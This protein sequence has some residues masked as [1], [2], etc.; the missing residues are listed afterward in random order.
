MLK[1]PENIAFV[2]DTLAQN[3]Y[4][5]YIVGG[6]VRDASLGILPSDFDVTTSAKPKEVMGLFEKT[7]PTGIKHGTVTVISENQPV[8]VTTFRTDGEYNDSRH[9]LN[10]EFVANLEED[11]SRRDFTVNA[12]AYNEGKGLI[13]LFG[14]I[15]DLESKILRAVGD[16]EKRFKEDAL[17]ILRLFRFASQLDFSIEENTLKAALKLQKGLEKI[18]RERIFSEI[19]K[20][21]NGKNPKAILPL[22]SAGGLGFL[23]ITNTPDFTHIDNPDLKLF[24]FLN[25]SS[26]DPVGV[27]RELKASNRQIELT[28]KLLLLQDTEIKTRVQ[29]K[30]TLFSTD[31]DSVKLYLELKNAQEQQRFLEEIIKN[32]E[33]YLI[34]HLKISGE[35]LISLGFKGRQIGR[36]LEYLRQSV[37]QDKEKNKKETLISLTKHKSAP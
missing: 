18:S 4:E 9:P 21:V 23:N 13:D 6:C 8:E 3:G 17:R 14:G 37:V 2:L 32:R 34:S 29:I 35:D 28:K 19:Q 1:I 31:F 24:V 10:V 33:P 22:I 20:A 7:V 27:L 11:L 25:S 36:L 26:Y 12:M 16:P 5:A 30:N 15:E